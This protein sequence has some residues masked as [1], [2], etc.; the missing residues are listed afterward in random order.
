MRSF[1]SSR[2]VLSAISG[3]GLAGTR[4][5]GGAGGIGLAMGRRFQ[6]AGM[7]IALADV[8]PA[9]LEAAVDAL[10]GG[11]DVLGVV[12]DVTDVADVHRL[13]DAVLAR[14]GAAHAVIVG[15]G[16]R[17]TPMAV[18]QLAAATEPPAPSW[19]ALAEWALGLLRRRR[20]PPEQ[21][22]FRRNQEGEHQQPSR[23][24][25]LTRLSVEPQRNLSTPSDRAGATPSSTGAR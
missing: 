17:T 12:C 5:R 1:R 14:F 20:T 25:H 6:Q 22:R 2:L 8:E 4:R 16:E 21:T 23:V 11:D 13:R 3:L 24:A 7:R 10:G 18:E 15:M 9:A 19:S